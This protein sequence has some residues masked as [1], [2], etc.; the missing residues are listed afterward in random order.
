[1]AS[2]LCGVHLKS[3]VLPEYV[4]QVVSM[5]NKLVTIQMQHICDANA[6]YMYGHDLLEREKK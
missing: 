5:I 3:T 6:R 1:M 4:K 2:I